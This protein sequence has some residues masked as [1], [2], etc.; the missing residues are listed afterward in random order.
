MGYSIIHRSSFVILHS[1][2]IIHHPS[3]FIIQ[4]SS[5]FIRHSSFVIHHSEINEQSMKNLSKINQKSTKNQSKIVLGAPRSCMDASRKCLG[6]KSWLIFEGIIKVRRVLAPFCPPSAPT[7]L[8]R[9]SQNRSWSPQ[10]LQLGSQG[11]PKIG[12]GAPFWLPKRSPKPPEAVMEASR[13]P[14]GPFKR[15]SGSWSCEQLIFWGCLER[16]HYFGRL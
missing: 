16:K 2:F 12:L 5:L 11:G 15:G 8:P 6:G 13:K 1:S 4:H 3:S 9:G 14:L 10:V 7:W